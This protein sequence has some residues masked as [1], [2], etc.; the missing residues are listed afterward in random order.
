MNWLLQILK[1]TET[2]CV[3]CPLWDVFFLLN[4]EAFPFFILIR[5]VFVCFFLFILDNPP[6]SKI[7]ELSPM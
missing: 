5:S 7:Y 2:L 4:Y 6:N 3:F 1:G